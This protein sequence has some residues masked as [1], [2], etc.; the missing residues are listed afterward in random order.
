MICTVDESGVRHL[1]IESL[2]VEWMRNS[3][4][5]QFTIKLARASD[6]VW[7][8]NMSRRLVETGLPWAW[9]PGRIARHIAHRDC[10][11][12]TAY[13]QR[14]GIGFAIMHFGEDAAHLNLLC[15]DHDRQRKGIGR[16]L[17][18]WLEQ[19]AVVAGT[20]D[21]GLE[22]RANN[23]TARQFYRTLGYREVGQVAGYYNGTEDAIRMSHDLRRVHL[24]RPRL[25][26][27]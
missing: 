12:L 18:E 20:F 3:S 22:V 9:T 7:M 1:T 6:N 24:E 17:I 23:T 14:R 8:A 15:V 10:V 13:V 19:S 4:V 27:A 2:L 26:E 5:S 11:V 16:A 25:G 21:V